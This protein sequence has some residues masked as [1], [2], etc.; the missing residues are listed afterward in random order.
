M[1]VSA[2]PDVRASAVWIYALKIGWESDS[3]HA[4]YTLTVSAAHAG[5]AA[6]AASSNSEAKSRTIRWFLPFC[7]RRR[8]AT[9]PPVVTKERFA[10]GL[11][12]AEYLARMSAN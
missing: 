8:H 6:H 9:M 11:T 5:A 10:Q 3:G 7:V 2:V 1:R 12:M 4:V